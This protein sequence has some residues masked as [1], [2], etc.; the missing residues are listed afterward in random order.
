MNSSFLKIGDSICLY[1]D[2]GEGYLNTIGFNHMNFY[3]QKTAK[4]RNALIPNQRHMVFTVAPK[5]NYNIS[6]EY[7]T[8]QR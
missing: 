8:L 2:V 4:L 6:R 5:L 7:D 3:V 1:T